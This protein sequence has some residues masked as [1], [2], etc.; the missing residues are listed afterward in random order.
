MHTDRAGRTAE[1]ILDAARA[2]DEPVA[3]TEC[4][5]EPIGDA[6]QQI[7]L[8]LRDKESFAEPD[9]SRQPLKVPPIA[10]EEWGAPGGRNDP[11]VDLIRQRGMPD[12]DQAAHAEING[13]AGVREPLRDGAP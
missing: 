7:R 9:G 4:D 10:T 13:P 5:S 12:A 2:A 6:D 8:R 11:K 1:A 3:A